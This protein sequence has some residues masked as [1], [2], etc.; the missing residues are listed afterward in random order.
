MQRRLGQD[1][2]L[3]RASYKAN[4][5]RCDFSHA[6]RDIQLKPLLK[7]MTLE[8]AQT[9]TIKILGQVMEEKHVNENN[10]QLAQVRFF[11]PIE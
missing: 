6:D 2:K 1:Q 10:V 7:Q 5:I 9:L 4:G 8:E 3:L 11:H